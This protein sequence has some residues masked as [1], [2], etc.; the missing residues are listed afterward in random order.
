MPTSISVSTRWN[1]SRRMDTLVA[2]IT[3]EFF[4]PPGGSD[5]NGPGLLEKRVSAL[6]PAESPLIG[7]GPLRVY[8]RSLHRHGDVL[9]GIVR[10]DSSDPAGA[11]PEGARTLFLAAGTRPPTAIPGELRLA[12]HS[13]ASP[14]VATAELSV[15]NARALHRIFPWTQPCSLR[16]QR[17]TIG[18][19]DRLGLATAGHIR[20]ARQ[21][22]VAPVLAQ[23]S[24]RENDLIGRTFDDVVADA[25]WGV[26]QEGYRSGYGADGDH[27]KTIDSIDTALAAAMPM[28]TLDL[29]EVM[30]P[31]VAEWSDEE[32]E[33][34]FRDLEETFRRRVL[35]EYA[36]HHF[37]LGGSGEI[38]FTA[39][40]ARRCAVM[41]GP[42]IAF[43]RLVNDHLDKTT[44]GEYDLEISIDETTTPTLPA[45]HLFI[46]RELQHRGVLV[47]SLAPRFIGEFQKAV[48]YEGD[49][50]EF[51][52]QFRRHCLIAHAYGNY[53]I[54]LHS[55][56][57][58]FTVY[59]VVGRETGLRVHLK[60]SGTSWLEGLRTIA[61]HDPGLYRRIHRFALTCYPRALNYY[62]VS[63]D[64]DAISPLEEVADEE[65]PRFLEDD[66]AR[67]MLHISYG[68]ILADRDLKQSIHGAL[69]H[70]EEEYAEMLRLHFEK[71]IGLLGA[72]R[73]V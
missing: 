10:H 16:G 20:A 59:P 7:E 60:T 44:G 53:K 70:L 30:R 13:A 27:L 3:K 49:M 4:T 15:E 38:S 39:A 1:G 14:W 43:S 65:L 57:D 25:T 2:F 68:W 35:E 73:E 5:W 28:I 50:E 36:G 21:F 42:A 37:P 64:F 29:T 67:Q 18:M 66:N 48:D 22:K 47:N 23:Q 8:L 31:E 34:E 11:L 58:K 40:E 63:A 72:P 24:V 32:I 55:G 69:H 54:S 12:E 46:A 56:S 17:T 19:G 71:H 61:V 62:H 33:R 45:H 41:Y 6:S 9:F 52:S 26:F 51:T